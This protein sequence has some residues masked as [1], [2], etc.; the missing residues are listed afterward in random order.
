MAVMGLG[1]RRLDAAM[2]LLVVIWGVNFPI[3]KGAF[4]DL[5]PFVFNGL[6]FAGAGVLLLLIL[7]WLEGPVR[8]DRADLRGLV[9]LGLLGHAGYQ[10]LFIAGLARTTAGHSSIILAMVPL[11]VG[12]LGAA[13]GIE[14][15]SA[16]MWI[17]LVLA[18][19]GVVV[20]VRSRTGL[21]GGAGTLAGDLITLAGAL[22]WATYTVISRPYLARYSALRLTTITL[23]FGLP[24]I[25][26]SAVPGM[27]RMEWSAVGL[28]AWGALAFSAV[29]A[30]VV[31]YVIWYTSVQIVGSAR[32]AAFSNLIPIVALLSAW[33][34]L[35]EPIGVPQVIGAAVVL[36]GVWLA[37]VEGPSRRADA[38]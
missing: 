32:T 34:I 38:A 18:F 10:T 25:F 29:F 9:L 22:C 7:R 13:L 28:G 4:A 6:R 14:R 27:L 21:A 12:A 11:F 3:I 2:L 16:R 5:P 20:L 30:V 23:V 1:R 31:S 35:R 36:F 8:I 33:M 15:P 24:F 37:R 19:A 26:A 17:G